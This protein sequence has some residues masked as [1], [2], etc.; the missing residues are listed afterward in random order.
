MN[1]FNKLYNLILQSIITQ[2]KA[3]RKQMLQKKFNQDNTIFGRASV[4]VWTDFL[5]KYDNKT[6]DFIC[7]LVIT[8][9]IQNSGDERIDQI[10]KILSFNS[11]IDTQTWTGTVDQFI[12]KYKESV[13][14]IQQKQAAKTIQYL[15]SIP[16]FSQKRT[17][18]NG[19]V[20]YKVQNT[21][22]GQE[23]VRK[24][25]DLQW[26][27]DANPWCLASRGGHGLEANYHDYW[28][29]TYN[30]YPKAIAFQNG[31]LLAFSAN[32]N[33]E[34]VWW[35]RNDKPTTTLKLLNGREIKTQPYT[36]KDIFEKYSGLRFNRD[37]G[38]YDYNKTIKLKDEDLVDGHFPIPFGVIK[39]DFDC[40]NCD[41]LTSLE[42]GP[43]DVVCDFSIAFCT[44][45]KSL[46]GCPQN[47]GGGFWIHGCHSIESL[48]N[49]PQFIGGSYMCD[50]MNKLTSLKGAPENVNGSFWCY[51]NKS[52]TTLQ[53]GPKFVAVDFDCYNCPK[54][55]SLKGAPEKVKRR[56]DCHKTAIRNLQGAPKEVGDVFDCGKCNQLETLDGAP[57]YVRGL[58]ECDNCPKLKVSKFYGKKFRIPYT[59]DQ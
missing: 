50:N 2:N 20:T 57:D 27:E 36:F 48:E 30:A 46:K 3:Q 41:T 42:N 44:N 34:L 35:D 14:K 37:S 26:G 51:N 9:R 24:I 56:F 40:S 55:T 18:K 31:K 19:V 47:I 4:K 29:R 38:R 21:K 25:I 23:A 13:A 45:L 6:A 54:L 39:G 58:F 7:K 8:D 15:D 17:Y 49:G 22:K 59:K 28:E 53:G 5:D 33:D 1:T 11:S 52:L 16:E 32:G 12:Q 43:T 10:A